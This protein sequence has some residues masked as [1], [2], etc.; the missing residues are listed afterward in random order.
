[1]VRAAGELTP[2]SQAK[3]QEALSGVAENFGNPRR[4][5]GLGLRKLGPGIWESSYSQSRN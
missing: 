2:K 4:H 3:L 1:M 5:A